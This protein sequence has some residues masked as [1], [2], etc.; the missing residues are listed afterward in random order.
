PHPL[1]RVVVLPEEAQDLVVARLLRVE[2]DEHGLGVARAAGADLLVG[3][4]RREAAGVADGRGVDARRL[5]EDALGAPETAHADHYLLEPF[6]E[7]R[8]ERRPEDVVPVWDP[9][10]LVAAGERLVGGDHLAWLRKEE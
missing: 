10:R 1:G 9:H 3:R 6:G 8:L 7:R 4:V 5:P 2:D